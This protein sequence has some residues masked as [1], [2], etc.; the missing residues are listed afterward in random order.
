MFLFSKIDINW[1]IKLINI[2]ILLNSSYKFYK[3]K[4]YKQNI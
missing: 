1:Q 3:D 2:K 4:I